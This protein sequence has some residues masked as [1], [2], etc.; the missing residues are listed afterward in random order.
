MD[1]ELVSFP[2]CP[3]A[4]RARITL[5]HKRVPHRV[6]HID[7]QSPPA[8]FARLS[9][10]GRVPL[11][12]VGDTALFESAAINEYLDETTPP[13]LMPDDP[14]ARARHRAWIAY[15]S[16]LQGTLQKLAMA[17]DAAAFDAAQ[18]NLQAQLG[19]IEGVLGAGPFFAGTC[20]SLVDASYAPLFMR[21]ALLGSWASLDLLAG[22]PRSAAW[23]AALAALPEVRDS[24]IEDFP[25]RYRARLGAAGGYAALSAAA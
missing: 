18:E 21:L 4:Q 6:T 12:R 1:L 23:A 3:Y 22:L 5:L 9:P 16:E 19:P 11:L 10:L 7:M 14:L 20:F 13:R 2:I 17:A 8:W 25:Q 24:M 15:A